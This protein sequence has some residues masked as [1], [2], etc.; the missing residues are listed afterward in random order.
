MN[1]LQRSNITSKMVKA[2]TTNPRTVFTQTQLIGILDEMKSN[3][4][5]LQSVSISAFIDFI[6]KESFLGELRLEFPHRSLLR[7][8]RSEANLFELTQSLSSQGYLSHRSAIELHGLITDASRTF[9]VNEEQTPKPQAVAKMQQENIDRTFKK[10]ARLSNNRATYKDNEFYVLNGKN[11]KNA[12]TVTHTLPNNVTVRVTSLE[13]TLIDIVVRP[14]YAGGIPDVLTA[15]RQASVKVDPE[16]LAQL[17]VQLRYTYPY[18]QSIG[19]YMEKS[20]SYDKDAM[21]V[22]LR[23]P[24]EYDF[25]LDH[26]MKSPSFSEKW[27]IYYPKELDN[28]KVS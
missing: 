5:V 28:I 7:F 12:G 17:L 9:Y 4:E 23:I 26:K 24:Q 1:N 20:G 21:E 22:F 15:Y 10:T 6:T 14:F 13:R 27:R 2:L 19:F 25:Y 8:L 11:T 18:H 16:V 3:D